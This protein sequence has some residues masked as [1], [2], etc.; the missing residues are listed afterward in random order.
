MLASWSSNLS[1]QVEDLI[2][3]PTERRLGRREIADVKW[4][5]RRCI[6]CPYPAT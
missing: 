1:Q 6:T 2:G 4:L 5:P 3:E